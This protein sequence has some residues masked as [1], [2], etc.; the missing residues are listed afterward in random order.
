VN[1][2][3]RYT[4][5]FLLVFAINCLVFAQ[6]STRRAVVPQNSPGAS[7]GN[8]NLTVP[9]IILPEQG[10]QAPRRQRRKRVSAADSLRL[11]LQKD[12]ILR[13]QQVLQQ[14]A[15]Q[16]ANTAAGAAAI[17]AATPTVN[18]DSLRRDSLTKLALLKM[19]PPEVPILSTSTNPFDILRGYIAPDSASKKTVSV[20][21]SSPLPPPAETSLLDKKTYSRNFPFW[22]FFTIYSLMALVVA[23]GRTNITS[24]YNALRTDNALK[25]AYREQGGM[26]TAI[27]FALYV[28]FW[29]NLATFIFLILGQ[30]GVKSPYGQFA[31]FMLCLA[32]VSGFYALKYLTLQFIGAVFPISKEIQLYN[33]IVIAAGILT[34]LA[35]APLNV[36]VA[37]APADL[38]SFFIF[39]AA[40]A[41]GLIYLVRTLR[42]LSLTSTHLASN[43]FHFLIYL[44]SVEIAPIFILL[45]LFFNASR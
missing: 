10:I 29:L 2:Q 4:T 12:S 34:G 7:V 27:N 6:D 40:G 25:Q 42:S 43:Q 22:I 16:D 37:Y 44:C 21:S 36:F 17:L 39:T 20:Q 35:L 38:S 41:M 13:A 14:I 33:F 18:V 3:R 5:T 26:R 31:T 9:P 23:N 30:M 24:A 15:A 1:K 8:P 11:A 19:S 45:K 28:L 32:G